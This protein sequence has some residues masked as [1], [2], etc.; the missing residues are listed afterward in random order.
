MIDAE[1]AAQAELSV[2]EDEEGTPYAPGDIDLDQLWNT[3][4][5]GL[6]K[7]AQPPVTVSTVNPN[8]RRVTLP[9]D[10][11]GEISTVWLFEGRS[12]L[13]LMEAIGRREAVEA[14]VNQIMEGAEFR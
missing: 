6:F 12:R 1:D 9:A 7:G 13:Y 4:T 3:V 14:L 5:E 8:G 10:E 2:W 11:N